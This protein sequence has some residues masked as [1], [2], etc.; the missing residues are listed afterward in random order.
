MISIIFK[1][2]YIFLHI[3]R[4]HVGI[5]DIFKVNVSLCVSTKIVTTVFPVITAN[6][7]DGKMANVIN[8][9]ICNQFHLRNQPEQIFCDCYQF[10]SKNGGLVIHLKIMTCHLV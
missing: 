1:P 4:K 6:T 8:G 7:D 10:L 9:R 3:K 5:E 2:F